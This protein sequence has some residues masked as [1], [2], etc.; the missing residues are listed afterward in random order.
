MYT[1]RR[2]SAG[3]NKVENICLGMNYTVDRMPRI[4]NPDLKEK[5]IIMVIGEYESH[6]IFK[7]DIFVCVMTNSGKTFE[8][9]KKLT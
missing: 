6:C 8:V 3:S 7:D 2:I 5:V 1:L 9:L 4:D